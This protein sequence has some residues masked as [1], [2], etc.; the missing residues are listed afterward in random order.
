MKRLNKI[1][2]RSKSFSL[3]LAL[4]LSIAGGCGTWLGNPDDAD[5]D[6][7]EGTTSFI[8]LNFAG[9]LPGSSLI[10]TS[11]PVIGSD[12]SSAGTL[13]LDTAK[14]VLKE[15]EFELES[16]DGDS[17]GI[18][19]K[20][21]YIVDLINN[22]VS[23][24]PGTAEVSSGIYT[25]IKLKMAKLEEDDADEAGISDSDLLEKSIYLSG[26]YSPAS[27]N[28][29]SFVLSFKLDE[30]FK[31]ENDGDGIILE[32][33][34]ESAIE[35]SFDLEKWFDLSNSETNSDGY[36]FSDINSTSIVLEKDGEDTE[37]ELL[38]VIKDNIKESAEFDKED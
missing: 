32:E 30:E 23:P 2:K 38:E 1:F 16:A 27:G 28:S 6:D 8:D 35:V 36:D 25:E 7:S 3:L 18:D 33:G 37:K 13:A 9:L 20:G 14:I 29:K 10:S 19:F 15:V 26:T 24:D 5:E 22:S 11:I 12:G 4:L 17:T 34:I 21:P 31:I